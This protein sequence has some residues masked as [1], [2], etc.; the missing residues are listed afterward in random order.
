LEIVV[1]AFESRIEADA[2]LGKV[3]YGESPSL[4]TY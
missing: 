2:M 4:A 3:A 1:Q